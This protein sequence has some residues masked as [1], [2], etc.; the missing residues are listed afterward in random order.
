MN[1]DTINGNFR[2]NQLCS[3]TLWRLSADGLTLI[4]VIRVNS[5]HGKVMLVRVNEEF[6]LAD[7]KWLEK[8]G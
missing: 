3:D 2:F 4:R 8:F 7:S 6:Q 5:I 1:S